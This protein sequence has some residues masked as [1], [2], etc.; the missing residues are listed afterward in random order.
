MKAQEFF[1]ANNDDPAVQIKDIHC[2]ESHT[3]AHTYF[4]YSP[5][6]V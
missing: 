4:T 6:N 2:A 5:I 3:C 1:I